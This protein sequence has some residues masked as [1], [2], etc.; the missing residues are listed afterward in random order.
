VSDLLLADDGSVI[1]VAAGDRRVPPGDL[2]LAPS[3]E[4]SASGW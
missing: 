4:P 2:E 1:E 3:A